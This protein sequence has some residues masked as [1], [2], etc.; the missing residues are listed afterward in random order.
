MQQQ[1]YAPTNA[2]FSGSDP[3]EDFTPSPAAAQ[4]RGGSMPWRPAPS[5]R[6][7]DTLPVS[8]AAAVDDFGGAASPALA[9]SSQHWDDAVQA[10]RFQDAPLLSGS[11][12]RHLSGLSS[13]QPD[14]SSGMP[15]CSLANFAAIPDTED[16]AIDILRFSPRQRQQ[17]PD[18]PAG[19]R[20]A[21]LLPGA[22]RATLDAV[23]GAT[24]PSAQHSM[25][26][27]DSGGDGEPPS[28][29][30]VGLQHRRASARGFTPCRRKQ[31]RQAAVSPA[32]LSRSMF[33]PESPLAAPLGT[34]AECDE[35]AE[36]TAALKS[37]SPSADVQTM[38][39]EANVFGRFAFAQPRS[40]Y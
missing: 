35:G 30:P 2:G 25:L 33:V 15:Q 39:R 13:L 5:T 28:G 19:G 37:R 14:D 8:V 18:S 20:L 27:S 4:R 23:R 38:C 12:E 24:A 22:E 34:A 1:K 29:L 11:S 36:L 9:P 17:Q 40:A 31:S 7:A 3:V 26:W 32:D 21:D 16:Q 6:D 10:S